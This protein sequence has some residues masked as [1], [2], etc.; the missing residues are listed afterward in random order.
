MCPSGRP[1]RPRRRRRPWRSCG[2]GYG[3]MTAGSRPDRRRRYHLSLLAGGAARAG[4]AGGGVLA[5]LAVLRLRRCVGAFGRGVLVGG[6]AAGAAGTPPAAPSGAGAV[7]I[8]AGAISVAGRPRGSR[9]VCGSRPVR[10]SRPIRGS[11]LACG[12]RPT[13]GI[14]PGRRRGLGLRRGLGTRRGR[15]E[16]HLWRLEHRRGHR[17]GRVYVA[18]TRAACRVV[19]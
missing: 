5:W 18:G 7:V 15:L 9:P 10:R 12:F 17:R 1:S 6:P 8:V 11:R 13:R 16:H 14:R 3:R 4:C 2:C 19:M